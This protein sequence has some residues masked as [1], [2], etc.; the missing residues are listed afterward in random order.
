[1]ALSLGLVSVISERYWILLP[2]AVMAFHLLKRDGLLAPVTYLSWIPQ[3][4]FG[5]RAYEELYNP[6]V[7]AIY[8][9]E[10]HAPL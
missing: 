5:L 7:E 10:R 9:R 2:A 6:S 8:S 4:V 1:V 3:G